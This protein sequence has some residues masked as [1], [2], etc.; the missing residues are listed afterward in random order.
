[1]LRKQRRFAG[2]TARAILMAKDDIYGEKTSSQMK[3]TMLKYARK[4]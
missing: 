1:M 3:D 2:Y 4:Q